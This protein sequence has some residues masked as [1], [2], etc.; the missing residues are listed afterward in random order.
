MVMHAPNSLWCMRTRHTE[1]VK[2]NETTYRNETTVDYEDRGRTAV[3]AKDIIISPLQIADALERG[4]D[5]VVLHASILGRSL[6]SML[7]AATIMGTEAI[8]EV[9]TPDECEHALEI[10][11][12][13]LM[14]NNWDRV[15]GTW[16]QHQVGT[17]TV[18]GRASLGP[19]GFSNPP[20]EDVWLWRFTQRAWCVC[21]RAGRNRAPT[22]P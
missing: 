17:C 14:V 20:V 3:I 10:G 4:A 13:T 8:V 7:D 9:H 11:A 12:T 21:V 15:D 22:H 19:C 2:K 18:D 5:G 1:T 6:E 16:H